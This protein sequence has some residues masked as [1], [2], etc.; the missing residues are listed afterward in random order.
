MAWAGT[1]AVAVGV[2]TRL[3]AATARFLRALIPVVRAYRDLWAEVRGRGPGRPS[4]RVADGQARRGRR[5]T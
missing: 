2:L 5:R 3:P 4:P 1:A